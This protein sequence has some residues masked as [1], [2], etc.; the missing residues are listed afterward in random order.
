MERSCIFQG[1]DSLLPAVLEG[2][3]WDK[4]GKRE[5]VNVSIYSEGPNGNTPG[6]GP[7]MENGDAHPAGVN[8]S[9]LS[10]ADCGYKGR[11]ASGYN[12]RAASGL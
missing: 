3:P 8:N 10:L 6:A 1:T 4:T 7:A 9:H 2:D 11:L 5:E 12:R